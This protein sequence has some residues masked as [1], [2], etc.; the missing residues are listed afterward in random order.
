MSSTKDTR[1]KKGQSGN[2][3]GRPKLPEDLRKSKKM[4]K[5]IFQGLLMKYLNCSLTELKKFKADSET[6]ALD[7]IV[8]SVIIN[9]ISK[10]DEKRLGFLM[11]RI[12]GKVKDEVEFSGDVANK[13]I[14]VNFTK[15]ESKEEA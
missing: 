5:I 3:A 8:I 14:V 12:I 4:N 2:P 13:K 15:P 6:K 9:A 7:R 11:D 1:F 10:G